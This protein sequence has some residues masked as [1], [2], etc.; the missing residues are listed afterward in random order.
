VGPGAAPVASP[1]RTGLAG[2]RAAL[3]ALVVASTLA[4]VT[5]NDLFL[6]LRT[7]ALVLATGSVPRV[8]DY[9]ALARGRPFVAHEWLAGVIFRLVERTFGGHGFDALILLKVAVAL[10]TVALL[11]RAA[12]HL[13]ADPVVATGCAAFVTLLAAARFLERPHIFSYALLAA[14]LMILA[15]RRARRSA[16]RPGGGLW[17]LAVLEIAWANLHGSFLLGPAV[18][19]LAAAAETAE[20]LTGPADLRRPRRAEAARLA[21]TAAALVAATLVNPYGVAL[22]RFPFALTGSAFMGQIYEWLPP[23]TEPFRSTYMARYYVLWA[24]AGM[25]VFAIALARAGRGGDT[26][27]GLFPALLF[28]AFFVLSLRMNRNVTDFALATCPGVAAALTDLLRQR[29]A[30]RGSPARGASAAL[31]AMLLGIA[32]W[33]VVAG[34]PFSASSRRPFGLGLGAGIPAAAA[35]YVERSGIRGNTFNTYSAGAY[36][37]YRFH[38][39]VRVGMDSR[40][41]VYGEELWNE[42]TRALGSP[43]DL[44]RMLGRID[45]RFLFIEWAQ[46]GL[47]TTASAIRQLSPAWRPVYFDDTA[48]VYLQEGGPYAA[49]L[50]RDGYAL[51]DPALFRPASWST[52][53][54]SAALA[55]ADRAV[56]ASGDA[57]IARVMRVEAL[58]TLGR[59]DEAGVEEA[60]LVA[61]DPPLYHIQILLG[62]AHLARGER[63]EAAARLRRALELNPASSVARQALD[64]ALAGD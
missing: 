18:V 63:A 5:N 49:V 48:V 51:L 43:Q 27:R 1:G 30:G 12:A 13:G 55:E 52:A 14:F 32:A 38:P 23:W 62:L 39:E 46:P 8:D 37:V 60:R 19:G 54:A 56:A 58:A 11:L 40:N 29:G 64:R 26:R 50:A 22:L 6:H 34:Y 45:A 9:S 33:F 21:L 59:R 2:A 35:D 47:M 57:F 16:G 4:P 41:D 31:A 15:R 7:G 3:A 24:A 17:L 61:D 42:Y 44:A 25:A 10:L 53:E 36:L 20:A 28:A